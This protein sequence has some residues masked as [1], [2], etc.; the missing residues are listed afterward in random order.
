MRKLTA[1]FAVLAF[2]A[3]VTGCGNEPDVAG[4]KA[5]MKKDYTEAT[6]AADAPP[7]TRPAECKGVDDATLQ[8]LA[9]EI[10][11]EA[12]DATETPSASAAECKAAMNG[13]FEQPPATRPPACEGLD[14]TVI[15]RMARTVADE[16]VA[17][18]SGG[19]RRIVMDNRAAFLKTAQTW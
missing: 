4:C 11:G 12:L 14:D 13:L 18:N 7:A 5:A 10:M 8:R 19:D 9:G 1:V 16:Y 2:L 6:A 15:Q 3:G 17:E